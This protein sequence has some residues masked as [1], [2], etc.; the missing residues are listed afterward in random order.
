MRVRVRVLPLTA[1]DEPGD[2]AQSYNKQKKKG[3]TTANAAIANEKRE[4]GSRSKTRQEHS[5]Q[6]R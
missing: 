1:Y 3:E 4:E 6:P 5:E 2:E